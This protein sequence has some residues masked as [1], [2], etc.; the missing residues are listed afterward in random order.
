MTCC[1]M[2]Q[3]AFGSGEGVS[4]FK[5]R[6][7]RNGL[8]SCYI[9]QRK[10]QFVHSLGVLWELQ[11]NALCYTQVQTRLNARHAIAMNAVHDAC[12]TYALSFMPSSFARCFLALHCLVAH[13]ATQM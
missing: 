7:A 12:M 8:Q 9:S 2:S 1:G 4:D 5:E 13:N 11:S 3:H 10:T 6:H